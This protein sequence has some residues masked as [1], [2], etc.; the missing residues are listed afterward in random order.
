MPTAKFMLYIPAK[1]MNAIKI[2]FPKPVSNKLTNKLGT[3]N[4]TTHKT[5]SNVSN[6]TTKLRFFLENIF[7]MER[8]I[9]ILY[10]TKKN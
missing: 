1:T 5:I 6:P 4:I 2:K 8:L 10:N 7:E 3:A 9:F